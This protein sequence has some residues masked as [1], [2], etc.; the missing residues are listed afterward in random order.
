MANLKKMVK[1][2]LLDWRFSRET[3]AAF[4]KL[5]YEPGKEFQVTEETMFNIAQEFLREGM[6]IMLIH[7]DGGYTLR[8]DNYRFQQRG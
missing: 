6:N 3:K 5:G 2:K 1:F 7:N 8:I 4:E